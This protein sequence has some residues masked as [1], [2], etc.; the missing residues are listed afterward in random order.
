MTNQT[1]NSFLC[2]YFSSLH[3]SS[4]PVLIIRRINN[5][6]TTSGICHCVGGRFVFRSENEE[7]QYYRYN[8]WYFICH[9]VQVTYTRGCIV[10]IDSPDDEHRV[11]RNIQRIE[12]N[13]QKIIVRQVGHLPRIITRCTVNKTQNCVCTFM[14]FLSR[15]HTSSLVDVRMCLVPFYKIQL[16]V[17]IQQ[18]LLY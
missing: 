18:K 15:F 14:V 10:T 17:K 8:L 13:T 5:I 4:N 1:H 11:A 6:D 2:I 3:V 9:Y 16:S 7:N 12:I